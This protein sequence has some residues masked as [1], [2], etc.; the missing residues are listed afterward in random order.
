MNSKLLRHFV[1]SYGPPESNWNLPKTNT[2]TGIFSHSPFHPW[3]DPSL[4][5]NNLIL[6]VRPKISIFVP[7]MSQEQPLIGAIDQ[8]TSSSRFLVRRYSGSVYT[9][10][11]MCIVHQGVV[12]IIGAIYRGRSP[13]PAH[14]VR[15]R[16]LNSGMQACRRLI[17]GFQIAYT[18]YSC[19]L[20]LVG[21]NWS[22]GGPHIYSTAYIHKMVYSVRKMWHF[23]RWNV[24]KP[25]IKKRWCCK[26]F[27]FSIPTTMDVPTMPS[28]FQ[29]TSF[30]C[31]VLTILNGERVWTKHLFTLPCNCKCSLCFEISAICW[32]TTI[33]I[34]SWRVTGSPH[35][36]N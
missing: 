6:G 33:E 4:A 10:A 28:P 5:S 15:W 34:N 26:S 7:A 27:E 12:A 17:L 22:K 14:I 25:T 1:C 29:V 24:S 9:A 2:S 36:A 31:T 20:V 8:G 16:Y 19:L 35:I 21:L 23:S 30:C 32:C 3:L 11:V 18:L 13:C